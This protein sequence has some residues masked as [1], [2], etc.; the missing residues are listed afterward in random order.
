MAKFSVKQGWDKR[1]RLAE[2]TKFD[3]SNPL[4]AKIAGKIMK[5]IDKDEYEDLDA[6]LAIGQAVN[7]V[8]SNSNTGPQKVGVEDVFVLKHPKT[9]KT[10]EVSNANTLKTLESQGYTHED[11]FQRDVEIG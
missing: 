1:I 6:I 11:F 10:V 8:D 9:N 4:G 5:C 7:V 2:G 3:I